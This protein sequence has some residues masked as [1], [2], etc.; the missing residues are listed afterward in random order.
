MH[1]MQG[2]TNALTNSFA[3][4]D[5][6]LRR[7]LQP[8]MNVD[9]LDTTGPAF[10]GCQQQGGGIAAAAIGNTYGDAAIKTVERC[11]RGIG[12]THAG[13]QAGPAKVLFGFGFDVGEAAITLQPVVAPVQQFIDLQVADLPERIV[14]RALQK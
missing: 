11:Q 5:K 14:E 10:G 3:N 6:I 2:H 7:S 1:N 4:P 8:V 12:R 9:G 13:A